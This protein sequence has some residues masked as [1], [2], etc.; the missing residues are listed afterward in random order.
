[1][2]EKQLSKSKSVFGWMTSFMKNNCW[3]VYNTKLVLFDVYVRS[4]L[5]FG[6][7]VW[8]PP[9]LL[10]GPFEG[11]SKLQCMLVWHR[12]CLRSM[13]GLNT[14]THNVL[15]HILAARVP[16]FVT[17]V[18]LCRRYYERVTQIP[19]LAEDSD[20]Y[21]HLHQIFQW[22][23][24][25][26]H[27]PHLITMVA[28]KKLLEKYPDDQRPYREIQDWFTREIQSK[29]SHLPSKAMNIWKQLGTMTCEGG[30]AS[31]DIPGDLHPRAYCE[32]YPRF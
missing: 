31:L 21:M 6:A 7:A 23:K 25:Y 10:K 16:M 1:M 12:T 5:Q 22:T 9:F 18:K 8:A 17:L 32:M 19:T 4:I 13:L 30:G 28:G 11:T 3:K 27:E 24:Q 26:D 29:L 14:R 2:I 15:T 20:Q